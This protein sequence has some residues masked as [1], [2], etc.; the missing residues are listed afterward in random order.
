MFARWRRVTF[1]RHL[2][3][4]TAAETFGKVAM[5]IISKR[6]LAWATVE[7]AQRRAEEAERRAK[8]EKEAE[9]NAKRASA[10]SLLAGNHNRRCVL[11]AHFKRWRAFLNDIKQALQDKLRLVLTRMRLFYALAAIRKWSEGIM[12]NRAEVAAQRAKLW[13]MR[14][15]RVVLAWRV[16]AGG[17][18]ALH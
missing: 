18:R 6:W 13:S 1:Y 7:G 2:Q 9:A 5:K 15:G 16:W 11:L 17:G 3:T 4:I 10:L 12:A 8:A 14:M